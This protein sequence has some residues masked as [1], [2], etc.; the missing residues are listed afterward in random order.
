MI[1]KRKIVVIHSCFVLKA[2][3]QRQ[4]ML[5]TSLLA[6]LL[7]K[8]AMW[9][10]VIGKGVSMGHMRIHSYQSQLIM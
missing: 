10:V 2:L 6:Q 9:P 7:S 1:I 4:V 3:M 8:L 5:G